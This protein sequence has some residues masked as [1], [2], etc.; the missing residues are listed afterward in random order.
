M[1][2]AV[3]NG[4][5]QRRR[6]SRVRRPRSRDEL[7]DVYRCM[8]LS[9]KL[10]DKEIQLKN[11]SQIFFQISGAGHEAVLVAAGLTCEPGYDWFYPVLSR[12][13]A[14]PAAR[15]DA[16]RDAARRGRRRRTTRAPAA[17][18]CR[19]TGA[20]RRSTSS[21]ARARPARRCCTR[22]AP[23]RPA[24]STAAS[25][26]IPDRESRFHADEIVY[27]S[28]GEGATSEGEFWE[29]LNAACTSSCRCCSSSRTT[30]T[31]SRCRSKCRRRAAT[32]R[33]SCARFPA[34][35][36][37]RSTAPTSSPA[38]ARCAR[39]TAYVRARKGP[40]FVHA[41]VHPPVLAL[42]VG[43]RGLYKTPA[44]R[45][46]EAQRDPLTRFA[47]VPARRTGSP[48]T[49]SSRRS[50]PT[51]SARSNEAALAGARGA[52]AGRRTP[53]SSGVYS[54]DVDPTSAAFETPAQPEGKPDTMVAAINRTLKDE[55]A[56]NPRIVVFGEDVA[57]ASRKEALAVVAGQGR[58]V[59]GDARPAAALRRRPRVQLAARRSQHR[60][61][62]DRH[63]DARAEAGGRDPVLR[64]HLAGDDA[65]PRRDV[66]AA[67]P[68]GQQLVV[69]DGDPRADR[70]LPARRRAVPQPVGREHLRA[71]PGHPHRVSRRTR[72]DAAG[73]LRTAIRCDDPVLFLEHKHL[74]RQTYN[75]GE[76]PGQRLHDPVRQGAACAARATDVLV[77]TWGALV[78]RSL[79]AAQQ[80]EKDGISVAVLD[81]RTIVP[82]DWDGDRRAR[83]ADQ[84]R[85]RSRTRI[86]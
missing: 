33:G 51:S 61:P 9:R 54:P 70:R 80:A 47:R 23:P 40:A 27:V 12:S 86:S 31:R 21:R 1:K 63:G 13:R 85:R 30:A 28:L 5:R 38:C 82:Y 29:A 20:T 43:R 10:D 62:R 32:S 42:A 11:Q 36:S 57:D 60:R 6:R 24:S 3:V 16:A 49:P 53:P 72:V 66:D 35:T 26:Q 77:I 2:G 39:P 48:P 44:E 14:V 81:L 37:I 71:L 55:M 46:A 25:T 74:Y 75:K 73:L 4:D 34:C 19:R 65:D 7:L 78:Q 8:L 17:A 52:E 67:L 69:P 68:L 79:L 56:R 83:Q 18:R 50:P 45:E 84:P 76:Y 64:L 41:H 59:Q 58:R 22:S 15:H